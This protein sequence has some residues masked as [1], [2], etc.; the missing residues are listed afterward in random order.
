MRKW[1]QL[2]GVAV[3]GLIV[4]LAVASHPVISAD[5][6]AEIPVDT[7]YLALT[8]DD[9]P[10]QGTTDRLLD[11]LKER[12]ANATFFLVGEW[13][14]LNQ[15]LVRRMRDE[16]HQIGNHT[17]SH[18]RLEGADT[19]KLLQEIQHNETLLREILGGEGY[20]LR[21]P[22]GAIAPELAKQVKVPMIKWSVD[23]RDWESRDRKKIVEAVL[24]EVEPNSIILL[25]DI[26]PASVEAALELI[27]LLQSEGYWFVTV[28]ELMKL[29]GVEPQN[30][31]MYRT[32]VER[33]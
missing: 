23:P 25:H 16:G 14:A 29:N 18:V 7:K 27:D 3:L 6:A 24:A 33:E 5:N 1:K 4:L 31:V 21:P 8:F 17:W 26:Y 20:W 11:G 30:G 28:K 19:E 10:K 22:Y 12:G 32:G 9:G 15:D 13:A 2:I